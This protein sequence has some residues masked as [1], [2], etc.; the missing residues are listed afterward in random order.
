MNPYK[1]IKLEVNKYY[2]NE[3]MKKKQRN[4]FFI[5]IHSP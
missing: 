5:I 1:C 3:Q 4:N 2:A